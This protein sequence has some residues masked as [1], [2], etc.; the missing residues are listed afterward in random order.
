M[1]NGLITSFPDAAYSGHDTAYSGHKSAYSGHDV[2][3]TGHDTAYNGHDAARNGRVPNLD[4]LDI[5]ELEEY[6]FPGPHMRTHRTQSAPHV[7]CEL[8]NDTLLARSISN[9]GYHR[10]SVDSQTDSVALSEEHHE[11]LEM[12]SIS[13]RLPCEVKQEGNTSPRSESSVTPDIPSLLAQARIEP[14]GERR[15]LV[16]QMIESVVKAHLQTCNYTDEK[17]KEGKEQFRLKMKNSPPGMVRN[18]PRHG[19]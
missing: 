14:V 2:P 19:T 5:P 12:L 13:A 16:E 17:V 8:S 6:N 10:A 15:E 3:Y 4:Q 1:S 7:K 9:G 11:Q 18:S